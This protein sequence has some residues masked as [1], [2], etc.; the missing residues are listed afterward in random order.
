M[1][2]ELPARSAAHIA[3]IL[4]ARHG[5]EVAPR[6]IRDQLRRQGLQRG[7]LGDPVVYG[8]YEA[9]YPNERWIGDVLSGPYVPYPQVA[10]SRKA[11]L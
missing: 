10:D 8:R 6:T 1:R 3:D 9:E 4:K 2:R 11:K 7:A 5:I